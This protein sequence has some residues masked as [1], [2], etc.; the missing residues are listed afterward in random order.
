MV[1][2]HDTWYCFYRTL[3]IITLYWIFECGF[4]IKSIIRF[5]MF[6]NFC[7]KKAFKTLELDDKNELNYSYIYLTIL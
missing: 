1:D 4:T 5:S 2:N 3:G 6:L 7:V